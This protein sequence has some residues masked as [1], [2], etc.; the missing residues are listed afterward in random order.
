MGTTPSIIN[1]QNMPQQSIKSATN[2]PT[3]YA[4]VQDIQLVVTN[5]SGIP[6]VVS[7]QRS[8]PAIQQARPQTVQV[9]ASQASLTGGTVQQIKPVPQQV[10]TQNSAGQPVLSFIRM[11][12]NQ[13]TQQVQVNPS[14]SSSPRPSAGQ[15]GVVYLQLAGGKA[16]PVS[17]A[18]SQMTMPVV[19]AERARSTAVPKVRNVM[20]TLV[21]TQGGIQMANG[22]VTTS[23]INSPVSRFQVAGNVGQVQRVTRPSLVASARPAIATVSMAARQQS[24][25]STVPPPWNNPNLVIRTRRAAVQEVNKAGLENGEIPIIQNQSIV[26]PE[27][28]HIPSANVDSKNGCVEDH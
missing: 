12:G 15:Q 8:S 4:T 3:Q 17:L 9:V 10:I 26:K 18:S 19:K 13:N 1:V 6:K 24:P 22:P 25:A 2:K 7:A 27:T 11:A 23:R 14:I 28:N 21:V 5:A 20:P 16:I